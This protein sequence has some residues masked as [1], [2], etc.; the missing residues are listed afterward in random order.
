MG[1]TDAI[2]VQVLQIPDG[3]DEDIAELTRRLRAELS[4]LNVDSID[5]VAGPPPEPG[6]RGAGIVVGWLAVRLGK[7]GLGTVVAA[8]VSWVTRTGHSVEVTMDGE[9]LK[10]AAATGAQQD[11][12]IKDFLA[13]H[14]PIS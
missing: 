11:Q 13:R 8:V 12:I 5:S 2:T 10:V 1:R 14:A 7:E 4:E 3:D 9:T 6:A